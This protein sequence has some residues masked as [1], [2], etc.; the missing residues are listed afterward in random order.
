VVNMYL[1]ALKIILTVCCGMVSF[2]TMELLLHITGTESWRLF[3]SVSLVGD[4][5]HWMK[6]IN[7]FLKKVVINADNWDNFYR[8]GKH[9]RS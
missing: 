6:V 2:V 1:N 4:N 5:T 8:N 3:V 7:T 9:I